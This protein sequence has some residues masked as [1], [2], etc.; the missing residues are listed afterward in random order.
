MLNLAH[1]REEMNS[2]ETWPE[3]GDFL[4]VTAGKQCAT[5]E[6]L[7]IRNGL[8]VTRVENG[9]EALLVLKDEPWK[10][11][12]ADALLPDMDGIELTRAALENQPSLLVI[13]GVADPPE[14]FGKKAAMAGASG[15]VHKPYEPDQLFPLLWFLMQ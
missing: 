1:N 7:L 2:K 13:L 10:V 14:D 8:R 4:F 3:S 9:E 5:I 11:L 12:V 15:I 6:S